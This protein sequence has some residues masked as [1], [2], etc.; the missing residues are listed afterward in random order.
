MHA[1]GFH[2]AWVAPS[3]HL[4]ELLAEPEAV[5]VRPANTGN[6]LIAQDPIQEAH[7]PSNSSPDSPILYLHGLC[8]QGPP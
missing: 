8:A 7:L 2:S 4:L 3:Q 1:P 5:S 6:S